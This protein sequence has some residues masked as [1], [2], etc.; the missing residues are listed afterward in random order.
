MAGRIGIAACGDGGC[1]SG[2][3]AQRP[4]HGTLAGRF[5]LQREECH[6]LLSAGDVNCNQ[7]DL[8]DD[9]VHRLALAAIGLALDLDEGECIGCKVKFEA[10][11]S[12]MRFFR[13][14]Q[15]TFAIQLLDLSRGRIERAAHCGV[16]LHYISVIGIEALNGDARIGGKVADVQVDGF[17]GAL[18]A[19][20]DQVPCGNHQAALRSS[21]DDDVFRCVGQPFVAELVKKIEGIEGRLVDTALGAKTVQVNKWF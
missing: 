21:G 18:L 11:R 15:G 16:L 8:V 13:R 17:A 7:R 1:D 20:V 3:D 2:S 6:L 5:F 14:G 12:E 19:G 9:R 10:A 4:P